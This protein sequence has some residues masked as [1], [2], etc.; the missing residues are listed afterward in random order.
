MSSTPS[1]PTKKIA[2]HCTAQAHLPS[3]LGPILLARTE[4][5]LAGAWFEAQKWHPEPLDAP[6][7][8]DDPLLQLAAQQ[9]AEYF[10][11]ERSHFELPLDL[12]GTDFQRSVWQALCHIEAG[13]TQSYAAV[14]R[15]LGSPQA[16][17]AVGAAV[18]RN[19][20][21]VIVPCH[22]VVGTDGS[23]TGYAGGLERKR[24]LLA[25][26]GAL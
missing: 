17:R 1:S 18:G 20:V 10:A 19:P 16:V 26:E 14:A 24:A 25:L 11:G 12:H 13:G 3:P 5:G 6:E 2:M 15:S 4:A 23:L 21:S 22:R 8:P 9:I 7:R